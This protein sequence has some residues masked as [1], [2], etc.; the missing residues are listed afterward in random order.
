MLTA[1]DAALLLSTGSHLG[2]P[3][4]FTGTLYFN[5]TGVRDFYEAVRDR[6][7]IVWPLESSARYRYLSW[8]FTLI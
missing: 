1:G 6:V 3:P 2:G 7:S 5:M 4:A 8:P